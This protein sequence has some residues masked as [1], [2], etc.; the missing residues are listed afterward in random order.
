MRAYPRVHI[1]PRRHSPCTTTAQDYEESPRPTTA[2]S[3]HDPITPTHAHSSA[4][5]HGPR[6]GTVVAA[7]D[8]N[9]ALGAAK[10]GPGRALPRGPGPPA[11]Q[12]V[13]GE[14][15]PPAGRR[16]GCHRPHGKPCWPMCSTPRESTPATSPR[17]RT[18]SRSSGGCRR[19]SGRRDE[20]AVACGTSPKAQPCAHTPPRHPTS[21][22]APTPQASA[23][24]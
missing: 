24:P 2:T 17:P 5:G 3:P 10:V 9:A 1:R 22:D 16:G 18:T 13:G 11:P 6:S 15:P 21:V 12:G 8:P 7:L 4:Q 14:R 23:A 19:R 20:K